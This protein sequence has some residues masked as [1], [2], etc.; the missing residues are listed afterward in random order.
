[1]LVVSITTSYA[2]RN[3]VPGGIITLQHDSLQ[4]L[5]DNRDWRIT[6]EVI[7]F[8][9]SAESKEQVFKPTEILGF[10]VST[11]EEYYVSR[12]LKMDITLQSIDNLSRDSRRVYQEDTVFLSRIISGVYNLYEYTDKNDRKHYIFDGQDK[13]AE[14]LQMLRKSYESSEGIKGIQ[15]L[16]YFRQQ[17]YVLFQQCEE[18][19]K[20]TSKLSYRKNDL[21][22]IF[23]RY[24]NCRNPGE[25]ISVK[26][27]EKT[28]V[29]LGLMAGISA[30]SYNI[31]GLYNV[32]GTYSN[33]INPLFGV[34]VSLPFARSREQF[35]LNG[36]LFYKAIKTSTIVVGRP[37]YYRY[38]PEF[39]FSYVQL[40]IMAR[41]SYPS[42]LIRPYIT[43]GMGNALAISVKN[44][45]KM[46]TAEGR[47]PTYKTAIDGPRVY[48]QSL[49]LGLGVNTKVWEGEVRYTSSNG[50]SPFP[51]LSTR[52]NS[53]QFIVRY[54]LF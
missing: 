48:E 47:E 6:P 37:G 31:K 52:V 38:E 10:W 36:E 5:I 42:K 16:P 40:N 39:Q 18:V 20:R 23:V 21:L 43:G 8:K 46:T 2:Q 9:T 22:D 33:S 30:N 17:L 41:Y 13:P 4:G 29:G 12:M 51:A 54:M 24:N 32:E 7:T 28:K 19:A 50:F 49:L 11:S 45:V 53:W 34:A 35:S 26:K 15:E 25:T 27:K 14:D 3:Y 1:M 44:Q